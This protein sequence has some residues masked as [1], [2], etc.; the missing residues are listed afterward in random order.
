IAALKVD[1]EGPV[2]GYLRGRDGDLSASLNYSS[3]GRFDVFYQP[4]GT[5]YRVLRLTQGRTDTHKPAARQPRGTCVAEPGVRL[6]ELHAV[7]CGIRGTHRVYLF[8][9]YLEIL[10]LHSLCLG[11]ATDIMLRPSA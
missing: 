11:L 2:T 1:G 4:V 7:Q 8:R 9:H 10:D 6:A 5:H 3:N